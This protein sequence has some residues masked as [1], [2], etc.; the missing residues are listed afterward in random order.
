MEKICY[1]V[2]TRVGKGELLK[3]HFS[4][5]SIERAKGVNPDMRDVDAIKEMIKDFNERGY[6]HS[7]PIRTLVSITSYK[8]KVLFGE[9]NHK[10]KWE[11]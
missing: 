8:A 6:Y 1:I 2:E 11:Y 7:R 5:E 9:T 10:I 4:K 3:E